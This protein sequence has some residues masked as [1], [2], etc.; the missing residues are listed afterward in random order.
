MRLSVIIPTRNRSPLLEKAIQSLIAQTYS[1]DDFEVIIVDNG[2]TDGTKGIF[3]S[4]KAKLPNLTYIYEPSPGLHVGRHAGLE[5]A[6]GD[7]LVYAD[8]DIEAFPTWLEGIAESF[9]DPSVA[10]VGGNNLPRYESPPPPWTE[11]LWNK[12]P[13]GRANGMYSILDFGNA[14]QEIS[15]Y[16]IWG[17][18]F[19]IRKEVL[20]EVGGFHPD[21]MPD[22]FL[23]Y[24]GDGESAVSRRVLN[25]GYD[26]IFNP[27]ASVYHFVPAKRMTLDYIH[28]RGY[29]QGISD[30]Y[31]SIRQGRKVDSKTAIRMSMSDLIHQFKTRVKGIINTDMRPQDYY[32]S[33]WLKGYLYH[34]HEVLKDGMLLAWI[35]RD[36]YFGENGEIPKKS[37]QNLK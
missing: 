8:D 24:R 37:P 29:I 2:S 23:R 5:I 22:D 4:Y 30:S 17:C 32:R 28:K 36:N 10:L 19:S 16:Y 6:R 27:K 33:G 18:N 7:I 26:T 14:I 21:G 9:E 12:T 13:F 1:P 11:L 25:S 35:L 3:E 15:P 34:Q 20:L 31:T